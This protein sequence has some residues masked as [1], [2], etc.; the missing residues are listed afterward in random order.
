MRTSIRAPAR[1]DDNGAGGGAGDDDGEALPAPSPGSYDLSQLDDST[2]GGSAGSPSGLAPCP[3]CGRNFAVDR[4]AKHAAVC[5]SSTK[6][7]R[8]FDSTKARVKGTDAA[9]FV[10][11]G[12][13]AR[14]PA[15]P[16]NNWRRK[17]EEFQ[18]AIRNARKIS[19]IQAAGGD[20]S[21]LPPPE[22]DPHDEYVPCPHCG[23]RFAEATAERHIPKCASIVSK[24]AAPPRSNR[25]AP[26]GERSTRAS[27]PGAVARI[28]ASAPRAAVAPRQ[29]PARVSPQSTARAAA[30]PPSATTAA[31]ARRSTPTG[32]APAGSGGGGSRVSSGPAGAG[33]SRVA[34]FCGDCGT[35]F[36]SDK[37]RFCG[38]CGTPRT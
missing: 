2:L 8:T 25:Y 35:A 5:T 21:A 18:K 4:L 22:Y 32:R 16:A 19:A 37:Q 34:K 3:N 13:P 7:R 11:A 15:V 6:K 29:A 28:G 30:P 36:S 27:P 12:A 14:A 38:E 23:R 9:A 1:N 33:G 17:H 10:R 24:P 31:T 20:L 26:G